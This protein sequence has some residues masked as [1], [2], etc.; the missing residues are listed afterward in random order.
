[1]NLKGVLTAATLMLAASAPIFATA[2]EATLS[3]GQAKSLSQQ[4]INNG[5]APTAFQILTVVT[6]NNPDDA[7]AHLL[8]SSAAREIGQ[9]DVSVD[10]GKRAYRISGDP[11][12]KYVAA[13]LVAVGLA[14]EEN[15]SFAQLWLRLARQYAPNDTEN[16]RIAVE[17]QQLRRLNPWS[18]SA[19]IGAAPSANINGGSEST[20]GYLDDNVDEGLASFLAAFGI[21]DPETGLR[22]LGDNERALSGIEGRFNFGAQYRLSADQTSATFLSAN[23]GAYRY[24]LSDEAEEI[25]PTSE[26][27]DFS[28]DTLSFG[29]RHVRV[30]AEDMRPATFSFGIGKNWYGGDASNRFVTASF[31]QPFLVSPKDLLTLG[32]STS[33]SASYSDDIP[34]RTF[35]VNAQWASILPEGDRIRTSVAVTKSNSS[36]EDSDYTSLSAGVTYSFAQPIFGAGVT[37]TS[38]ARI[39]N[40]GDTRFAPFDREDTTVSVGANIA[41]PAA[42]VFGFQP[43]VKLLAERTRS[44]VDQ[45]DSEGASVGFDFQS[46]F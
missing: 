23:L 31:S 41:I 26:N 22:L 37:L 45:F 18:F 3:V 1:M 34:I 28:R 30:L 24:R 2:Q 32:V 27:S 8:L 5:Q 25:S 10:A 15:Y 43:V 36:I 40:I 6:E 39:A 16:R 12:L 33:A 46:S 4:L 29:I 7:E 19:S 13:R 17:Y 14:E 20:T 9:T 44:T 21:Y 35:G 11:E 38:D 42:E